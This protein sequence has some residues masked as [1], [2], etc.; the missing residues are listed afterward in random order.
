MS[1]FKSIS[2]LFDFSPFQ[3]PLILI[4]ETTELSR[5]RLLKAMALPDRRCQRF[6]QRGAKTNPRDPRPDRDPQNPASA[7]SFSADQI[8]AKCRCR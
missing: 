1:M 7:L 5:P 3:A 2:A 4:G 8:V 6:A